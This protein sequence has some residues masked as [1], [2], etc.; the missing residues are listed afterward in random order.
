MTDKQ[1]PS[2]LELF[3]AGKIEDRRSTR[4][5][6]I[7]EQEEPVIPEDIKAPFKLRSEM[8]AIMVM[9]ILLLILAI[10]GM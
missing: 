9:V 8:V 6:H 5:P 3:K 7:L 4:R 10:A 2:R 1:E